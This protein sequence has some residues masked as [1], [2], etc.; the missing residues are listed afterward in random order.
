MRVASIGDYVEGDLYVRSQAASDQDRTKLVGDYAD[1]GAGGLSV[2]GGANWSW[3]D[4]DT[5][6]SIV[7]PG[8]TGTA[9]ASYKAQNGQVF[10]E[11]DCN[12]LAGPI[13]LE[14]FADYAHV[15]ARGRR[16]RRDRVDGRTGPPRTARRGLR[17]HR[18]R[19]RR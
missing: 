12:L 19:E 4:R 3:H 18:D 15:R 8:L 2:R 16:L 17:E 6:R 13:T 10:G 7:F 14:P 1:W 9:A 11:I 5:S